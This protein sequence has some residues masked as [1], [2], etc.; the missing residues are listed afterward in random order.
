MF[1]GTVIHCLSLT[2]LQ[3]LKHGVLGV[4][5]GQIVFLEDSAVTSLEEVLEKYEWDLDS[6]TEVRAIANELIA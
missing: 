2:D 1:F 5:A 6:V 3:V 4:D